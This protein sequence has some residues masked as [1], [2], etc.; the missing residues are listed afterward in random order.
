M[1]ADAIRTLEEELPVAE[2]WV[3]WLLCGC[4]AIARQSPGME[5][6]PIRMPEK[7]P[8]TCNRKASPPRF[9]VYR[10]PALALR[11]ANVVQFR[12]AISLNG[13]RRG[14]ASHGW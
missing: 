14:G 1:T 12:T 8:R 3:V 4:A 9:A 11:G 13:D 5:R 10:N 6:K 7:I 2:F